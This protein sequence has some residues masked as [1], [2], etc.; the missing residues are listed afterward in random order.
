MET[1]QPANQKHLEVH[2]KT[3]HLKKYDFKCDICDK[4]FIQKSIKSVY[5]TRYSCELCP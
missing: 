5:M 2:A 3:V 4:G 1:N